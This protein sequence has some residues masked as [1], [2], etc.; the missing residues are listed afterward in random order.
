MNT[1]KPRHRHWARR[2]HRVFG[3][4][5]LVFLV[6][7]AVS[8]LLL[9]HADTLGLSRH[10]AS[11]LVLRMYGV[12]IPPVD[13]AFEAGDVLFAT[14]S[15]MLF[16]DGVEL[17][18]NISE[19]SGAVEFDGGL[20]V[21]TRNEFFV[22]TKDARLIERFAPRSSAPFTKLG[23]VARRVVVQAG[24]K[25]FEFDAVHMSLAATTADIMNDTAWSQ[26]VTP[27]HEQAQQIGIAGLSQSMNWERVLLDLHSGRIL[28][29]VGR[30]IADLTALCLL[31]LCISG[32]ILWTRRR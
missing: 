27:N 1:P 32:L 16:A 28:P 24:G 10:A 31:Y 6:L 19:L 23:T 22:T 15:G 13:A 18:T 11:P 5:S 3:V 21:A 25:P 26:P 7:I 29:T 8:G 9:N 20:I 12:D 17:A 2:T 4:S 30:Y 14:S